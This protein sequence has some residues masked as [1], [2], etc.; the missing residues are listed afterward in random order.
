MK[1]PDRTGLGRRD[2]WILALLALPLAAVLF[3]SLT[4]R[5]FFWGDLL[6]LHHPWRALPAEILQRGAL[7]LWN[8]YAYLGSPLAATM[9]GAVW[10]PGTIPFYLFGFES[11]LA[12][13]HALHF[14]LAG[15]CSY[16][17]LRSRGMPRAASAAGAAAWMLSG[18]LIRDLPFLNHL[19]TLAYLPAFLLFGRR[20]AFLGLALA[21]SFLSGYPQ[22]LAGSAAAAW[23]IDSAHCWAISRSPSLGISAIAALTKRWA[24][25]G[26][27]SVGLS[28]VLLIP[29]LELASHS[30]RSGGI[31]SSETLT[32]SFAPKDLVQFTSPLL[33]ERGEFSPA[34]QWWKTVYWG[35]FGLGVAGLG[36]S[37]LSPAGAAGAVAYLAGCVLLMLGGSNPVSQAL[38]THVPLLNYVRY[39]GNTSFL[40]S[41]VLMYL[42]ARGLAGRTWA[43][44]GA[45]AI[46]LELFAYSW[47]AHPTVP[48]GYFTQAGPLVR[49][50][51]R[52]LE[53]HRYLLSPLA[54]NWSRGRGADFASA[55][56]DLKQR[57]YGVTNAPFRL[58]AAGNFGEPLVPRANYAVMD[59]LYSRPGLAALA[60][61]LPW[62]DARVLLTKDR[63]APG[64]LRYLGDSLWQLYGPKLPVERAYWMDDAAVQ[65]LPEG[66]ETRAPSMEGVVGVPVERLREDSLRAAG[67]FDRPGWLFLSE[68]F[69]PGWR[70][71]VSAGGVSAEP[72]SVPALTAFRRFRVP[73]G[74]WTFEARYA[75]ASWAMG[76]A[77][78]LLT[79]F[80]ALG[81]GFA[82]RLR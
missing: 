65:N 31:D 3:P 45:L 43:V 75:P 54:L 52:E 55:S 76:L 40:A 78:T 64:E 61:W 68:P 1:S 62:I 50:L 39:P 79:A 10:Y 66:L 2:L 25:A 56:L 17:W 37:R 67:S 33:V 34:F 20:P 80:A 59:H 6:Y 58:S 11:A 12:I 53:G 16:L 36:L 18:Q 42:I 4:G 7:P 51:Q 70:A 63:L 28:A 77:L 81:A 8:P 19:S 29:A 9:Q 82:R 47:F 27:F 26:A 49:N 13:F 71:S 30:R 48:R 44:W 14:W 74:D 5:T 24:L 72:E 35:V 15:A 38:W 46:V 22:M 41:P 21:L 32:F 60:P 69:Y 73:A 23:L 57:L